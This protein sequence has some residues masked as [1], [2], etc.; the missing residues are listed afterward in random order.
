[1]LG[2]KNEWWKQHDDDDEQSLD[3]KVWRPK[4]KSWLHWSDATVNMVVMLPWE[5]KTIID[6][7]EYYI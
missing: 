5:F 2:A 6:D 1:L 4:V 3:Q 7:T